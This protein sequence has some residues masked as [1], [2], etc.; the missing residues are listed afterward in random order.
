MKF[1]TSY[2]H[3]TA[4]IKDGALNVVKGFTRAINPNVVFSGSQY[5]VSGKS[6][7]KTGG[8]WSEFYDMPNL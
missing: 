2:I 6:C 4:M 8:K 1:S 5:H 3:E 7:L